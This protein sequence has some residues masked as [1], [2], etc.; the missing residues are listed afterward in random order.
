MSSAS[1]R[2]RIQTLGH[3]IENPEDDTTKPLN[4]NLCE[5]LTLAMTINGLKTILLR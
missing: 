4:G 5:K 1:L 3:M 2:T